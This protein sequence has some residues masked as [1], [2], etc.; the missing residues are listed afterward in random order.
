MTSILIH[1]PTMMAYTDS[2]RT[3]KEFH[4][5]FTATK[6]YKPRN[7]RQ[8]VLGAGNV[9][10]LSES[11]KVWLKTGTFTEKYKDVTLL[12]AEPVGGQVRC[13]YVH[14]GTTYSTLASSWVAFGSGIY[15]S[16]YLLYQ[17]H[18]QK[19]PNYLLG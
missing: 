7:H 18:C 2:Q 8:T 6:T 14:N 17:I 5:T 16:S 3:S 9:W 4:K 19:L 10:E 12:V 13:D 15:P 11:H 1:V